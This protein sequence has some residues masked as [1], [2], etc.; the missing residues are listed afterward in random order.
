MQNNNNNNKRKR[1]TRTN[2]DVDLWIMYFNYVMKTAIKNG[3]FDHYFKEAAIRTIRDQGMINV[4]Q[5]Q[6]PFYNAVINEFNNYSADFLIK[7]PNFKNLISLRPDIDS[8]DDT[9][10]VSDDDED[11]EIIK[12]CKVS[13]NLKQD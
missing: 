2:K 5:I 8:S 3:D 7:N 9:V 1:T 11:D 6:W 10:E 4:P 12:S 13:K